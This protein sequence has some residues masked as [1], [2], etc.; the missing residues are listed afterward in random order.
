MDLD[1]GFFYDQQMATNFEKVK[2]D[3]KSNELS[4]KGHYSVTDVNDAIIR[5]DGSIIKT[6]PKDTLVALKNIPLSM[7]QVR[8]DTTKNLNS[9]LS[10]LGN[11]KTLEKKL[12][13]IIDVLSKILD[14]D[15]QINLPPQT[16]GDL[17]II[18]S[19]GMI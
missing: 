19:G 17:D 16:R 18:M 10:G 3:Y 15:I 8:N 7:E 11:D 6:N 4:Q 1:Y 2:K 9:S 13:T 5:T 14:K 12:T